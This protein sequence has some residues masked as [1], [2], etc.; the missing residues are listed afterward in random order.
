M[1]QVHLWPVTAP[2][3]PIARTEVLCSTVV[4][5]T[6]NATLLKRLAGPGIKHCRMSISP[7]HRSMNDVKSVLFTAVADTTRI[8]SDGSTLSRHNA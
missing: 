2:I 7:M 5:P 3:T 8:F 4:G 6:S 1:A